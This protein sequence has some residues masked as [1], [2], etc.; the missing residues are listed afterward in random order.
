MRSVLQATVVLVALIA[1][2]MMT[3]GLVTNEPVEARDDMR[4]LELVAYEPVADMERGWEAVETD[5]AHEALADA[6]LAAP[7]EDVLRVA[8]VQ[9]D[10][11]PLIEPEDDG[12]GRQVLYRVCRVTAYCDRGTTASGVQSGVGQCA[13]PGDIPFGSTV[14]IPA[15]N[16]TFVV[17]DRTHKRF[18]RSTVDVFIPSKRACREFGC[19]YLEVEITLPP[20]QVR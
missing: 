2:V 17:T 14:Y 9:D 20:G 11:L 4:A 15:L 12:A 1:T 10:P 8:D 13:A 6:A 18:R 7:M 16:R 5:G 19:S 3:A